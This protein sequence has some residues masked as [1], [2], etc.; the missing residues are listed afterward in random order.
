LNI[1][2]GYEVVGTAQKSIG[3]AR[4]IQSEFRHVKSKWEE[5]TSWSVTMSASGEMARLFKR[6]LAQRLPDDKIRALDAEIV[7]RNADNPMVVT[8][9]DPSASPLNVKVGGHRVS[10]A[11]T[12]ST[13]E[14]DVIRRPVQKQIVLRAKTPAGRDAIVK[15]LD[16][17]AKEEGNRP[18]IYY[19]SSWGDWNRKP[20]PKRS[21]NTVILKDNVGH[22]ILA[23]L[24]R[25]V[26]SE[27]LY[28]SIGQPWHRGYVF[29]GPP[30]TGKTS[31]ALA[32]ANESSMNIYSISL[33]GIKQDADLANLVNAIPNNSILVIEDI[34][35][36]DATH[37]RSSTGATLTMSGL[38][39]AL[40][41]VTTPHGLV[42]IM[43][44]NHI[45][46]IDPAL[47]RPGRADL[48]VELGLPDFDQIIT[49]IK[50][51]APDVLT[52][53]GFPRSQELTPGVTT[54]RVTGIIKDNMH[55]PVNEQADA[56]N[57]LF[58]E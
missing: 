41:G 8:S 2:K 15:M 40:D 28:D 16:H 34:D 25:F 21:I 33:S 53:A 47:L 1:D 13:D 30:G 12:G 43:T 14:N 45:G 36:F 24:K 54:A 9:Y 32:L 23:D 4:D 39:N 57:E 3:L 17:I 11:V 35:I 29:Y 42:T 31:L 26:S 55:K 48:M 37:N 6:W 38:L 22:D 5:K 49:A 56:L 58:G 7:Y 50:T 51:F 44:T 19:A 52:V 18:G 46:S 10:I 20:L 27:D